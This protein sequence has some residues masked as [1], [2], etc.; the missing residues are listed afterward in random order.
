MSPTSCNDGSQREQPVIPEFQPEPFKDEAMIPDIHDA[1]APKPRVGE[2]HLS[3][4]AIRS[5]AKRIFTPRADGSKKVS[6]E[7]WNDWKGKGKARRLLEDIFRQCG[8][9]PE[10]C[11]NTVIVSLLY[12]D[13]VVKGWEP[14]TYDFKHYLGGPINSGFFAKYLAW[15]A[16]ET[17]VCEVEILKSEMTECEVVVEGQ[18]VSEAAME[19][20]GW[21]EFLDTGLPFCLEYGSETV[22]HNQVP[23]QV[24]LT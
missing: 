5:R 2:H 7:I 22:P 18:F 20:W 12:L 8:Y 9:D 24:L 17:F 23:K 21:S 6:D 13:L 10:T 3:P 4:E 19:E 16:E 1:F 15:T 14:K 11:L